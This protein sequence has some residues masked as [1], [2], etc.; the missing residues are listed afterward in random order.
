MCCQRK[1]R[2]AYSQNKNEWKCLF[3][4]GKNNTANS[5]SDKKRKKVVA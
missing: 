3:K 4:S 5:R 2:A 1:A